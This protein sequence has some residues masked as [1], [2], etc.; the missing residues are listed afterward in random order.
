M[1]DV[2]EKACYLELPAGMDARSREKY[3]Q[4]FV[5]APMSLHPVSQPHDMND[6]RNDPAMRMTLGK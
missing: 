5:R 4:S 1:K 2:M 3:T 6:H